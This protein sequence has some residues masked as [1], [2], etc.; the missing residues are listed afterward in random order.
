MKKQFLITLVISVCVS[1]SRGQTTTAWQSDLRYLQRTVH[2]RYA[3][4]FYNISAGDWDRKVDSFYQQI[5]LLDNEQ[6]TCGFARLAAL[7]HVGHTQLNPGDH[8][9]GSLF[10]RIPARFHWFTDGLYIIATDPAHRSVLGGKVTRI[11]KME[12]GQALEAMRPVVPYENEQ[13]YRDRLMYFLGIPVFLKGQGVCDQ[14]GSVPVTVLKDGK[15][16]QAEFSTAEMHGFLNYTG[17]QLPEG[18][19]EARNTAST[20][21]WLKEPNN[22]R[23]MEYLPAEKLLY[24]RHSVTNNQGDQTIVRFFSDMADYIDKHEVETLVLDIRLN[25]G[26]NNYLNKPIIT[27][28]IASRKINQKGKFFCIIGRKTFS[29]AQNLTNELEKYTEVTFVGEPTA[30][31]VNFFGDTKTETLP[32]SKLSFN[33][34]WLW[35]QNLDPR[36]KRK[37]TSPALATDMSYA[38]YAGNNDP[39]MNAVLQNRNSRSFSATLVSF[40][41]AGKVDEALRFAKQYREDPMHRY[42]LDRLESD[43]NQ[44]GY[45]QVNAN[46][47][48]AANTLFRV[49]VELFPESA[50]ALDSYAES[51]ML[52]GN[53][54]DAIKYY[55]LAITKDKSGETA[56][57]SRKMLQKIRS[58]KKD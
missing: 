57:N 52:M 49:N 47:L 21:L 36:D 26:G 39:A 30:E 22:F 20:P 14:T 31:N 37:A 54:P 13:G 9:S 40:A 34:S 4:L 32:E 43:I 58:G 3:N 24:V 56:E 50:N 29:A 41:E 38:D 42:M 45:T 8:N 55:E 17:I 44:E 12:T 2:E 1:L 6:I 28:I 27:S 5:P 16:I 11:G 7:F 35:W 15:T 19:I 10:N 18:W 48:K 23:Y 25:G 53:N 33:L 46:N 51:F